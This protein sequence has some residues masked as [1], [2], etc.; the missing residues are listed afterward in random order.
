LEHRK[1]K[2]EQLATG[3]GS[4]NQETGVAGCSRDGVEG[5]KVEGSVV[6]TKGSAVVDF[7]PLRPPRVRA[8]GRTMMRMSNTTRQIAATTIFGFLQQHKFL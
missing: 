5:E 8:R 7:F 3:G 2:A 4:G 1:P 6:C